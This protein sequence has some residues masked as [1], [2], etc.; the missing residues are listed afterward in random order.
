MAGRVFALAL[1]AGTVA[2]VGWAAIAAYHVIADA[3]IAPLHLSRDNDAVLQLR[4]QQARNLAELGRLDALTK[5]ALGFPQ[6]MQAW[7]PA[8]HNG[9]TSVNGMFA[10]P[11]HFSVQKGDKIY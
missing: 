9:G 7:F 5:P 11:T 6:S 8:I 4:V 1:L 3:W 10:P 2:G